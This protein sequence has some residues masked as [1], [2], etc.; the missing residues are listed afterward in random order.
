[1]YI[2]FFCFPFPAYLPPKYSTKSAYELIEVFSGFFFLFF[3]WSKQ[4]KKARKSLIIIGCC[5]H[6]YWIKSVI[7]YNKNTKRKIKK[8][9]SEDRLQFFFFEQSAFGANLVNKVELV[10]DDRLKC[11]KKFSIRLEES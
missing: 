2:F 3:I 9:F 10:T 7:F 6:S 5:Y 4:T 11:L 1:M 8:L